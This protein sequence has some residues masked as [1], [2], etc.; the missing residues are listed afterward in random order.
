M[1]S[2]F[3]SF[4]LIIAT[5]WTND[6]QIKAKSNIASSEMTQI[7]QDVIY[8]MNLVRINPAKF[9]TEN[10]DPFL[11]ENGKK[12]SKKY[13]RSLKKDLLKTESLPPLDYTKNLF[14]FAKHHA[15]TTGKTGKVGHRS[16]MMKSYKTR[17]KK[18]LKTYSYVGENIHYGSDNALQ[19]VMELLIDDGIKDVGHRRNILSKNFVF[20][21]ASMQ[22]HK[23]YKQNCVIE[24]GGKLVE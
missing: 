17:T 24:F 16:V 12:Y 18:L 20:A 3:L 10:L 23:R 11:K 22:P 14:D 19:I 7:E 13:V 15:K 5:N 4:L 6:E 1:H 2:V 9:K 8:Y 21:S